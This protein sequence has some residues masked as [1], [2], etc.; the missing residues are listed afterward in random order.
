VH[1]DGHAAH[2]PNAA[3]LVE[4]GI[5]GVIGGDVLEDP[6]K[7]AEAHTGVAP[8]VTQVDSV[9]PAEHTTAL[10]GCDELLIHRT[11]VA[12]TWRRSTNPTVKGRPRLAENK[13]SYGG[14]PGDAGQRDD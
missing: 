9:L 3:E 10:D 1:R 8:D 7:C 11:M 14:G 12:R 2:D 6:G 4:S 13:S 5:V